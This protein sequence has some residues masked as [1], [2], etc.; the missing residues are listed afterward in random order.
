VRW[1]EPVPEALGPRVVVG[2]RLPRSGCP[3]ERRGREARAARRARGGREPT[4]QRL[5]GREAGAARRARGGD[6]GRAAGEGA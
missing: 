4:T 2:A 6:G 5:G 1:R 3:F